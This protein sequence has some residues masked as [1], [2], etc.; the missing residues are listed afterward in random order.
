MS[1]WLSLFALGDGDQRSPHSVTRTPVAPIQDVYDELLWW[2]ESVEQVGWGSFRLPVS[3]PAF[4][5]AVEPESAG[6]GIADAYGCEDPVGRSRFAIFV[7]PPTDNCA[8][9]A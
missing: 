9:S 6:T 4:D 2:S 5:L 3:A 8:V 7:V 1:S